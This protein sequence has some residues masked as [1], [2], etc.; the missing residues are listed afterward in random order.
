MQTIFSTSFF[1]FSPRT[2]HAK[3]VVV[4]KMLW[5]Y[6]AITISLTVTVVSAWYLITQKKHATFKCAESGCSLPSVLSRQ[7]EEAISEPI[8][9]VVPLSHEGNYPSSFHTDN[10][11]ERKATEVISRSRQQDGLPASK[12]VMNGV[13]QGDRTCA[14]CAR[15]V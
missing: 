10:V 8:P 12:V 9:A 2:S 4:S 6:I 14:C 1:D 7:D 13:N 15:F 5:I 11:D 3:H